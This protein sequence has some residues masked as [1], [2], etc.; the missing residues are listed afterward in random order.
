MSEEP[1]LKDNL[2]KMGFICTES[3]GTKDCVHH[4]TGRYCKFMGNVNTGFKCNNSIAQVQA[5]SR[6]LKSIGLELSSDGFNAGIYRNIRDEVNRAKELFPNTDITPAEYLAVLV[7]EVGE[8]SK[9]INTVTQ[10]GEPMGSNYITELIH[11]AAVCVRMI[12]DYQKIK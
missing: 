8:V 1:E 11:V 10:F 5:I 6:Y 12:E 7:E 4:K 9:E 3:D 2:C